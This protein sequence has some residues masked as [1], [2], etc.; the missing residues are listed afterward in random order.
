MSA[1]LAAPTL[2]LLDEKWDALP[3]AWQRLSPP[4]ATAVLTQ[5]LLGHD[6]AAVA[7]RPPSDGRTNR[8]AFEERVDRAAPTLTR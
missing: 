2:S 8:E 6:S 4:L 3:P 5:A 7:E 1:S